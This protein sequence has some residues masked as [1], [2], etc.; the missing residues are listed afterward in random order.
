MLTFFRY[1]RRYI[2]KRGV[3]KTTQGIQKEILTPYKE[4]PQKTCTKPHLNQL[5][6]TQS[7]KYIRVVGP[8]IK[9][10]VL[11]FVKKTL[12]SSLVLQ[13]AQKMHSGPTVQT[14]FRSFALNDPLQ[15]K[16]VS[17]TEEGMTQET[18]K[19]EKSSSQ[20]TLDFSQ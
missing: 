7:I 13:T 12:R 5:A 15:P 17:C 11:T 1:V 19:R 6:L 9:N 20:S 10:N 16:R 8:S 4:K 14:R 3:A 18:Q 2:N